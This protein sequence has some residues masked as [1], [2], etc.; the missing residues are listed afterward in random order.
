MIER[1]N[2]TVGDLL[3]VGHAAYDITMAVSKHPQEDEKIVADAM[4]LSGGGPAANAAVCAARL[5]GR[6]AFFGYLGRDLFGELHLQELQHE[7]VDCSQVIRGDFP[8]PV[9]QIIAKPDGCRALINFKGDTPWIAADALQLEVFPK[10]ILLD[11]HEPLISTPLCQWAKANGVPTV[12]DAGSLH[13][14]TEELAPWVDYLVASEKFAR[15]WSGCDDMLVA[16]NALL[17]VNDTVVITLSERGLIWGRKGEKGEVAA[18]RVKAVDTTGAGDAFHGAFAYGLTQAM[19]WDELLHYASA[20]GA[21]T[22]TRL[23]A[24]AALPIMNV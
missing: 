13:R 1:L 21:L 12:L 17:L 24:R 18:F 11:G 2:E 7:G 19:A 20:I 6:A 23:G 22:C 5:G 9:S 4:Q 10:V 3:C 8:S 15:Q 16:L 14:G